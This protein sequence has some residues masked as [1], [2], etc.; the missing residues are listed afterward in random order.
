MTEAEN[1]LAYA[2]GQL[3]SES[4]HWQEITRHCKEVLNAFTTHEEAYAV[5]ES[6]LARLRMD[7]HLEGKPQV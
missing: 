7:R 4:C 6:D 5:L 3:N 1:A 2:T